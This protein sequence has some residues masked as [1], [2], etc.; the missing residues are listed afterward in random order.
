MSQYLSPTVYEPTYT[1]DL[2]QLA[3]L[4]P[5]DF[6][7]TEDGI[8]FLDRANCKISR[9]LNKKII[10]RFGSKGKGPEDYTNPVRLITHKRELWVLG[11]ERN[12]IFSLEGKWQKTIQIRNLNEELQKSSSQF[13]EISNTIGIIGRNRFIG[14]NT[15]FSNG[16]LENTAFYSNSA[17]QKVLVSQKV[18][19][20]QLAKKNFQEPTLPIIALGKKFCYIADDPR[21]FRIKIFSIQEEKFKPSLEIFDYKKV[22]YSKEERTNFK[23][24]MTREIEKTRKLGGISKDFFSIIKNASLPKYKPVIQKICADQ[25]DYLYILTPETRQYYFLIFVYQPNLKLIKKLRIQSHKPLLFRACNG[26]VGIIEE[27]DDTYYLKLFNLEVSRHPD[28]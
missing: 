21:S 18:A 22:T 7:M 28:S 1:I 17:K 12:V 2:E 8:F 14:Q 3:I 5:E 20:S 16:V 13:L 10:S 27:K 15:R 25:L 9:L 23:K 26:T 11:A 24:T 6:T 19:L 4:Q